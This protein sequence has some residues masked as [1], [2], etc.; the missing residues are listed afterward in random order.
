M[1]FRKIIT[2][3]NGKEYVYIKL[4]ENYRQDGKVKQRV[5]ANFGSIDNLAPDR[6]NSL[7]ASLRKLQNEIETQNNEP[8]YLP[9][10]S[11]EVTEVQ[12]ILVSSGIK[13][14][15]TGVLGHNGQ[16]QLIEALI[17]NAV[18]DGENNAPAHETCKNMGLAN[19]TALQFYNA[20]KS[21][22]QEPVKVELIKTRIFDDGGNDN[23]HNTLYVHIIKSIFEGTFFDMD[24]P[25]N[26][27]TP[28]MFQKPI[29]ILVA[30]DAAG[31][32]V[33]FEYVEEGKQITE[34]VR[35][36]VN[37]ITNQLNA[38]IIVLD[39]ENY[40]AGTKGNY[41]VANLAQDI[42]G[43]IAGLLGQQVSVR[44]GNQLFFNT[45]RHEQKSEAKI[46]EIQANLA[47]VSAGLET[48]KADIL[49]GKLSK[50]SAVR[51]RAE[52]VIKANNCQDMVSYSFNEA[53]Q[54]FCYQI[55][56]E[57]VKQ[58]TQ[59]MVRT[60]WVIK[61]PDLLEGQFKWEKPVQIE[62]NQYS[63]ITDRLKTPPTSMYLDY[64]YSA[65]II[66]GHIQLEIIKNQITKHLKNQNKGGEA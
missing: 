60:T 42:P 32:S 52:G 41:L 13:Q 2:K 14:S 65:A 62:T 35:D 43:E 58:K 31:N 39:P 8:T 49:L 16:Y 44:Q 64:H 34:P 21:L 38:T 28:K 63:L 6:I 53:T 1:F 26:L 25:G 47:K 9:D 57:V 46:K 37:R 55:K 33:D 66:S 19:A 23:F 20:V 45:V 30:C 40:L 36:L 59:S 10:F 27:I 61:N 17:I 54:N 18:V 22:G 50:E 48:I 12:N 4:I 3:K 51:K 5:V 29:M 7:I 56:D 15:I 24:V 11:T